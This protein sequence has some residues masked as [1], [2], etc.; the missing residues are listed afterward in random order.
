MNRKKLL[1]GVLAVCIAAATALTSAACAKKNNKDSGGDTAEVK[2]LF[3]DLHTLMP[4]ASENAT[5]DQPHPVNASRYIAAA[6]KSL[7]GTE[8][9]WASD[10]AKP[11]DNINN[12]SAWFNQQIN[13]K[14][15]P[16]IGFTF[17]TKMQAD[18]LYADLGEYLE[19]PNPYVAGNTRWKDIF[20][21]WVWDDPAV[22]DANGKIVSVPIVLHPGSATAIYYNKD[23]FAENDM[24]VPTTWNEFIK[25]IDDGKKV[26]GIKYPYVPYTGDTGISLSSWAF[27][28]SLSPGF[29]AH[30]ADRTDYDKNGIVSTNELIRAVLEGAFNPNVCQEAKALYRLAYNYYKTVLPGGW[31]SITDTTYLN[32]WDEGKVAMKNQGLW[33]YTNEK[34][35]VIRKF[36]FDLFAPPV[37]QSDSSAYASDLPRKKLYEGYRSQVLISF[38]VMLPAVSGNEKLLE[39]AIDFLMYLSAP[40]AVTAMVQENGAGLPAVK[41]AEYP[42]VYDDSAWLDREFTEIGISEWPLGFIEGN[43]ANINAAFS[44]WVFG[45]KTEAEFFTIVNREQVNG[46]RTMVNNMKINTAG[47]NI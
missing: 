31:E 5:P 45:E 4:S 42:S 36:D 19:R 27:R 47:W 13:I 8:I 46:A 22:T 35:D 14:N 7:T 25:T 44:D 37:A 26:P 43:T 17:G 2:K 10:Y 6:Y 11:T 40:E 34:S 24:T 32:A 38:N 30:M 29:A 1:S 20:E 12:I 16:A 39:K 23:M 33:Y 41:G 18:G 15:C 9:V 21:D 3:V 28:Y